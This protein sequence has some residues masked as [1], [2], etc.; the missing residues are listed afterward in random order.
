MYSSAIEVVRECD[1]CKNEDP[2]AVD[3]ILLPTKIAR[4]CG[5]DNVRPT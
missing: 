5:N 2:T 4:K 3:K 1:I